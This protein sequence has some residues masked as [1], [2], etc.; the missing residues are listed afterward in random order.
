MLALLVSACGGRLALDD[1]SDGG[2]TPSSLPRDAGHDSFDAAAVSPPLDA[3]V[4]S[5]SGP[6]AD[7]SSD[8]AADTACLGAGNVIHLDGDPGDPVFS[9]TVTVRA[10]DGYWSVVMPPDAMTLRVDVRRAP[11]DLFTVAL[12]TLFGVYE[13]AQGLDTRDARP[14]LVVSA[15]GVCRVITGRFEITEFKRASGDVGDLVRV[16]ASFEQHCE[17]T[18]TSLRGCFHFAR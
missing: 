15:A 10:P 4:V 12:E 14:T 2:G 18:N 5:D 6:T 7:A 3:A 17:A 1:P 9:G 11:A 16:T 8:G 13:N